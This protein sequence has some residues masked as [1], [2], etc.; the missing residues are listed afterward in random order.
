M[1]SK[2]TLVLPLASVA[3]L[4]SDPPPEWL[5]EGLEHFSS[6]LGRE[7]TPDKRRQYDE[8]LKE[9]HDA[10]ETLIKL[11]PF[12][13]HLPWGVQCPDEVTVA[14]GVLPRIKELLRRYAE[15]ERKGR[16]RSAQR[17][18]CA[19]VIVEAWK[20]I[21]GRYEPRSGKLQEACNEYW[22]ACGGEPIGETE[23]IDNWR[24]PAERAATGEQEWIR[25]VLMAYAGSC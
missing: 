8:L 16:P 12:F 11:L 21:H 3:R 19:A 20:I 23:D 1:D 9:A 14:L 18:I 24:R 15:M 6:D 5:V 25:K 13:H 22:R 4:I 2:L 10:T 17:D 7:Q